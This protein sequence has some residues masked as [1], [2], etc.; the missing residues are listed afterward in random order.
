[1][2]E[3]FSYTPAVLAS[4]A[5][6]AK[7]CVERGD[8]DLLAVMCHDLL[9][10]AGHE[11]VDRVLGT[12]LK[13]LLRHAGAMRVAEI[14]AEAFPVDRLRQG[15]NPQGA[16]IA[17]LSWKYRQ[18][19]GPERD[20]DLAQAKML[21]AAGE[22]LWPYLDE[23]TRLLHG[24]YVKLATA[25][26]ALGNA[27]SLRELSEELL[28]SPL[29]DERQQTVLLRIIRQLQ[30]LRA[31]PELESLLKRLLAC[32]DYHPSWVE[33]VL[34][35]V[36]ALRASAQRL[37]DYERLGQLLARVIQRL[38]SHGG[39]L[40]D[41]RLITALL[42]C[43]A[44]D[45][46]HRLVPH[47]LANIDNMD[48]QSLLVS[49]L[50][51]FLRYDVLGDAGLHIER[52]YYKDP[53]NPK[54]AMLLGRYLTMQGASP[55]E[56]EAVF[57]KLRPDAPYYDDAVAWR[58]WH[59]YHHVQH[60]KLLQWLSL[61]PLHD[62]EKTRS[63]LNRVHA[64][65]ERHPFP[66]MV[67]EADSE[68]LSLKAL[69][70]LAPVLTPLV[71]MVNGDLSPAAEPPLGELFNNLRKLLL[72]VLKATESSADVAVSDY[73][74]SGREL[75]R[76]AEKFNYVAAEGLRRTNLD[77]MQW[78]G[79][80]HERVRAIYKALYHVAMQLSKRVIEAGLEDFPI[81]DVRQL[82]QAAN[83]HICSAFAVGEPESSNLL[84]E[85]L[86]AR[87]IAA[88]LVL[89]LLER[90]A[91]QRGD[92]RTA[93][94]L[95]SGDVTT[96]GEIYGFEPFNTW[97]QMEATQAHVLLEQEP[98]GGTFEYI[99][100]EGILRTSPHEVPATRVE[101]VHVQGLRIRDIELLIGS[102]GTIAMPHSAHGRELYGY[103]RESP[104]RLNYGRSGCRVEPAKDRLHVQEPVIVLGNMDAPYW[105]NYYHW[106]LLI[107]TRVAVLLDRG[108]L[109][110]RRLLVPVEL[111]E[112][113][114][115]SLDLIGLPA[116]RMLRY[117]GNQEVLVDDAWIVGS[118][119]YAAAAL[120]KPLQRR[121]W[122]A[123]G[124]DPHGVG[125]HAVWLSRRQEPQRYLASTD[126]IEALAHH[127]GF[128]VVNP[129]T[130]SLLDQVRLC[131]GAKIIAGPEG[132]NF[133]NLLFA[134]SG[135]RVLTLMVAGG[136]GDYETWL[137]MCVMGELPQKWI[138]GRED[139]RKA[140]W[141]FHDE[142]YE[143]DFD[144]LER[145]LRKLMAAAS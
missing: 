114:M 9:P 39:A 71:T 30:R 140:W 121:M 64:A 29:D 122:E 83:M 4:L 1:M 130:L 66:V 111:S 36:A 127:L 137:D 97:V 52:A 143:V 139:P 124:I 142:P 68:R 20:P 87:H 10:W 92:L 48:V 107:L 62:P 112:W 106:M 41:A 3:T 55:T 60:R 19:F 23:S 70:S 65:R 88:P 22:A 80:Q 133:T 56:I 109:E 34:T 99:N 6:E 31:I 74:N 89:R 85:A 81:S 33:A 98:R 27:Q 105:R 93:E 103:P 7:A 96:A 35:A 101:L 86:R 138:F 104:I 40:C 132:S 51:Q 115:T 136:G 145:E 50:D 120:M 14:E 16:S 67:S 25:H 123:A 47:L 108:L 45:Q 144:V 90:C 12:V 84:L 26:A 58:A 135:T 128:N 32:S 141:G 44:F 94:R 37:S 2:S 5:G 95:V 72:A 8:P 54:A 53:G 59:H 79:P 63:L 100:Q 75:L 43:A 134:R 82:C 57:E 78:G 73:L 126:A 38:E 42:R 49:V 117:S 13:L 76:V 21:V 119:E 102:R 110:H 18:A 91:L 11:D 113:M 125:S 24:L 61:H 118:V 116:E 69:G 46:L 77:L 17:Y 129:G 28:T 15:W 131:A